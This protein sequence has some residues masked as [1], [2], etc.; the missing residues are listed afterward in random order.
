MKSGEEI[1][2]E[3]KKLIKR[4]KK[5]TKELSEFLEFNSHDE[6]CQIQY[7]HLLND[8][9][10]RIGQIEDI[11]DFIINPKRKHIPFLEL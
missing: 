5:F 10:V 9:S 2:I 3:L 4:H 6:N 7:A 11:L 1:T 8:T